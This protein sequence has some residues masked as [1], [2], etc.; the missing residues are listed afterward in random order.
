[1]T[2]TF[3]VNGSAV[4]SSSSNTYLWTPST[5]GTYSIGVVAVDAKGNKVESTK[6]FVVGSSSPVE[7]I[8]GDV[9]HDGIINVVDATLV[10]KYIVRL[11]DFDDETFKIADANN[12]GRIDITDAT[13]IQKVIV[14]LATI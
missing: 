11:A 13:I 14:N 2:Y 6:T 12:D 7:T 10:Q 8:K 3:T 1:M 9:N 5:D 4:Q